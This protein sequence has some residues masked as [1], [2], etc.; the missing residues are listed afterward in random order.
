MLEDSQN[1]NL[2]HRMLTKLRRRPL[3]HYTHG[4]TQSHKT[5][6]LLFNVLSLR[7][8]VDRVEDNSI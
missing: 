8:S 5:L 1:M 3:L 2:L 7:G 6:S 4:H